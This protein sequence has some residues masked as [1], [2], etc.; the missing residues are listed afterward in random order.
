MACFKQGLYNPKNPSKY[1]GD[2]SKIRY[3]S[4]WELTMHVFLDNNTKIIRWSS[5]TIA[6]PYIKPTDNRVHRYYPDYYVEYL[7]K[8]NKLR[9][10]VIEVK[11]YKQTKVSRARKSKNKIYEDIQYAVNLAKWQ[12][13]TNFCKQHGLEFQIVTE[14]TMFT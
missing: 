6:I 11:P 1:I 5:E 2:V 9:K 12:A 13:C 3:M 10:I 4:S 8:S 7:D 14:K